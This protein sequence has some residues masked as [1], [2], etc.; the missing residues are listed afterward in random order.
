MLEQHPPHVRNKIALMI[1]ALVAVILVAIFVRLYTHDKPG[2]RT[3][4]ASR[5][6]ESFFTT[7][8]DTTDSFFGKNNAI[9]KE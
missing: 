9:I 4:T 1:T 2:A 8:I 6:L 5:A 3:N 7:V